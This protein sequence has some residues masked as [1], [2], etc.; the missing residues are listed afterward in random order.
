MALADSVVGRDVSESTQL[1]NKP[2][3]REA[4]YLAR[5]KILVVDSEPVILDLL[6][7]A[8]SREGYE[9]TTAA[10]GEDALSLV[11]TESFDLAI[12]DVG[13]HRLRGR[14]VMRMIRDASPQTALV[15]MTGYPADEVV[16]FAQEY[17]QAYLEKPFDLDD[18]LAVLRSVLYERAVQARNMEQA[19]SSRIE[20]GA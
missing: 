3:A 14:K 15:A 10:P 13:L 2:P 6:R 17:A 1:G 8:L 18:L 9:V 4:D 7:R 11:S 16:T 5:Q 12:A 19:Q 20:E